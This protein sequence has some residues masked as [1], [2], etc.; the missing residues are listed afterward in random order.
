MIWFSQLI[1]IVFLSTF[2][3][4]FTRWLNKLGFFLCINPARPAKFPFGHPIIYR[5]YL[6]L[7]IDQ[8]QSRRFTN[9][10]LMLYLSSQ[11]FLSLANINMWRETQSTTLSQNTYM[12]WNKADTDQLR[13]ITSPRFWAMS[14]RILSWAFGS[15]S[16]IVLNKVSQITKPSPRTGNWDI[17]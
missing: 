10:S 9:K 17:T 3:L 1:K 4:N 16:M 13:K 11:G 7:E 8:G 14:F 12:D 2:T 5:Q 6:E 15:S